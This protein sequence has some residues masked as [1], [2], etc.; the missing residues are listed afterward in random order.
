M[1]NAFARRSWYEAALGISLLSA[2]C[3]DPGVVRFDA[4]PTIDAGARP[5]GAEATCDVSQIPA[6]EE[7]APGDLRVVTILPSAT[8]QGDEVIHDELQLQVKAHRLVAPDDGRP[9]RPELLVWL[10]GSGT[11]PNNYTRLQNLAAVAGYASVALAYDNE[12][13]VGELCGSTSDAAC[14]DL[15]TPT[16]EGTLRGEMVYGSATTD[17]TC[18]DVPVADSI[19]HRLLRLL[20]YLVAN[21]PETGADAY[22]TAAQDEIEWS[23]IVVAG[24]SQGGGHAGV[25]ARDHLVARAIYVS[26]GA[27]STLCPALHEDTTECDLDG[28]GVLTAGNTD[29]YMIPALWGPS[30]APRRRRA[31][32]GSCIATRKRGTTAAKRSRPGA[33]GPRSPSPRSTSL[34]PTTR[35]SSARTCCPPGTHRRRRVSPTSSTRR[36][37]PTCACRSTRWRP[38]TSTC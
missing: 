24:W 5:D 30:H 15:T 9:L 36:W 6:F 26:K 25:I 38:R 35:N 1:H 7:L 33:W 23:N 31:S 2:A 12:S 3:G 28:D 21:A 19:E 29:E 17:S 4:A 20:Q 34:G 32:S 18:H 16:C 27:G 8:A 14:N 11:E 10:A 13:S 37:P 22:L